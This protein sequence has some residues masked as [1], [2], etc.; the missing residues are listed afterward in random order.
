MGKYL[1]GILGPFTGL[2]GSIVGTYWKGR[3]V[4]RT[5]PV[6]GSKPP[7]EAQMIQRARFSLLSQFLSPINDI[8]T[9]GFQAYS[10][11]MS[12]FNAAFTA[13]S[14]RAVTG[15]YPTL[16]I[17]YQYVIIAKG[18]LLAPPPIT[19]ATTVDAQLD[20]SWINNA[21]SDTTNGA[22]R[23]TIVVCN[24]LRQEYV[25]ARNAAA[26]SAGSYDMAVPAIWAENTVYVWAFFVNTAGNISSNS[27]Y[28]GN[29][30]V[31]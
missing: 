8:L 1:K 13:N 19:M 22:D 4:M 23:L 5:R 14:D 15:T 2:V 12:P 16:T 7:T 17:D 6:S 26:R 11:E 21:G 18:R 27:Q 28:V 20:F 25:K 10:K 9:T 30:T 24:P 3:S 31:Q 29:T